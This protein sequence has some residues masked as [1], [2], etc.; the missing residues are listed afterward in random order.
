MVYCTVIIIIVVLH[1]HYDEVPE[2]I[3]S[4]K[5]SNPLTKKHFAYKNNIFLQSFQ[6]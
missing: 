1:N 4:G 5:W 6:N 3:Y 2:Y